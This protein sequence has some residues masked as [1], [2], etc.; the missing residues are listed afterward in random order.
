M[1]SAYEIKE[2]VHHIEAVL[3]PNHLQG[4]SDSYVAKNTKEKTINIESICASMV[5]RGGYDGSYEGSVR[6]VHHFLRE[7]MYQ[8]CNGFSVNLGW[9]TITVQIR[10]A[11]HS[12]SEP[13][14]PKTHKIVFKFHML[15][16]MRDLIRS[17]QIV[18]N[19]RVEEPAYI[20]EFCS[21]ELED[22]GHHFVPGQ[23]CEI[24]GQRV[25]IEG[26]PSE[27][28]L[29]LVPVDDPTHAVKVPRV[30][31]N[32]AGRL[33]FVAIST[34]HMDNRLEIRTRFSDGSTPLNTLRVITSPFIITEV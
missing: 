33:E 34:G 2:E 29:W 13:F 12:P 9:F 16:A 25:K 28:G 27:A 24:R 15:K 32:T 30:I 20:S 7:V 8:L 11:F 5:T 6:T 31:I 18:I 10:G 23:V 19:G 21:L 14:D 3:Y 26:A 1:S 4:L 22:G 17:I